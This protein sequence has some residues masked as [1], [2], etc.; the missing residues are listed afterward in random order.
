MTHVKLA[1]KWLLLA[2]VVFA[3][4]M[5]T[6]FRPTEIIV[7]DWAGRWMETEQPDLSI[8]EELAGAKQTGKNIRAMVFDNLDVL[9][10]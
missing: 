5:G 7:A 9:V 2:T 3:G 10:I 8:L 1:F 4:V 6:E